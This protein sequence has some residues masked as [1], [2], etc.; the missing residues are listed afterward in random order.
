MR[1]TEVKYIIDNKDTNT[2][3]IC[4]NKKARIDS[5]CV[6]GIYH[7]QTIYLLD[8]KALGLKGR[9]RV[10]KYTSGDE[11]SYFIENKYKNNICQY[12]KRVKITED[13]Y[14]EIISNPS[15]FITSNN[16]AY[17]EIFFFINCSNVESKEIFFNISYIRKAYYIQINNEEV[18][19]TIDSYLRTQLDNNFC[20]LF[21]KNYSILEIKGKNV[22]D[23]IIDIFNLENPMFF[24]KSKYK[25]SYHTALHRGVKMEN[26]II[27]SELKLIV[28]N[29]F[30]F[31]KIY[32][33]LTDRYS[34]S[35]Y[36][37]SIVY[38][39]YFDTEDM[40]LYKNGCSFRLRKKRNAS[41]NFKTKGYK[42]ENIWSRREYRDVVN[43]NSIN[44]IDALRIYNKTNEVVKKYIKERDLSVLHDSCTIVSKRISYLIK[45]N[46]TD[47]TLKP[48]IIGICTFDIFYNLDNPINQHREIEIEI[49]NDLISPYVFFEIISVGKALCT[50]YPL[51]E[52]N[53]SKYE[54]IM[55]EKLNSL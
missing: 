53:S 46:H 22:N 14:M 24:D 17:K 5:H 45:T 12:K 32:S 25:L 49:C 26:D 44:N 48:D 37:F 23:K 33:Y 47:E 19:I 2:L 40:D 50:M 41:L 51:R 3:L 38:D 42:Y 36:D 11:N 30:S 6:N 18:R 29:D 28:P 16:I 20:S 4:L 21:E 7:I 35:P 39:T 13:K 55:K 34:V 1:R 54:T 15:N 31:K 10:R 43:I 8:W 27:E 9:I 52:S